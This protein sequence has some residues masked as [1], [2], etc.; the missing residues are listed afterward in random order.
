MKKTFIKIFLF[1]YLVSGIGF[2]SVH[3]D[4]QNIREMM[5]PCASRCCSDGLF[6]ESPAENHRPDKP[7]TGS[8]D[9]MMVTHLSIGGDAAI[10]SGGCCDI[11]QKYNQPDSSSLPRHTDVSQIARSGAELDDDAPRHPQNMS[12]CA[13]KAFSGPSTHVNF[14]LLI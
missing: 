5:S 2:G 10:F 8:C 13:L 6:T 14:P 11:L 9:A 4:C 12:G 1:L 3:H 7:D